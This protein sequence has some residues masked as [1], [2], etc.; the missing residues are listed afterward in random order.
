M[1]RGRAIV[2]AACLVA[3]LLV[4]GPGC[5]RGG[6]ARAPRP[7]R[8]RR[9][10]ERELTEAEFRRFVAMHGLDPDDVDPAALDR[11]WEEFLAEVL[12]ARAAEREGI[13]PPSLDVSQAREFVA[14]IDPGSGPEER[15]RDARRMVLARL[16]VE[17]VLVPQVKV[18]PEE[19]EAA[20]PP[21]KPSRGRHYLVFRQIRLED[22][23]A[24]REA[25]RRV[26]RKK[27]PFDE[28]AREVSTAPDRGRL[29]QRDVNLLPSPVAEAL[30]RL[31]VGGVS[32]PVP[33]D[34]AYYLFELEAR[35]RDPDPGRER[36]RRE[37]RERLFREKLDRLV[38]ETLRRLAREEGIR[39]PRLG[40]R[41][42]EER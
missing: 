14:D 40:G 1:R 16:Y 28:V 21:G 15:E 12:L 20:L 26:V 7:D 13:E 4:P 35:N 19:V 39:P 37:V 9:V 36:E 27:E 8:V 22:E 31:P 25:W 10:G 23:G 41:D 29:Q 2:A 24:A 33:F 34:G 6:G 42:E 11:L 3:V 18:T 5:R 30:S 38:E 32:R 17:R